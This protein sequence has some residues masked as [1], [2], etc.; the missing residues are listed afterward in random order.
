[1]STKTYSPKPSDIQRDWYIVDAEGQTLGRLAT[2]VARVLRGKHKPTFA[3]NMD[4]GDCVV[5]VNAEK[6]RVTGNKERDK[7]YYRHS[8]YPGGLRSLNFDQLKSKHPTRP[9]EKAVRG[10]LPKNILGTQMFKKLRVYAGPD[11][12]HEAQQ[13]KPL[14]IRGIKGKES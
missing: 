13:P 14:H 9:I 1:M 3:P 10:M 11:H 8:Q 5:I 6:V 4:M 7:L 2:E 12:P